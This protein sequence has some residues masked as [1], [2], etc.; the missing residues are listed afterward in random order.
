MHRRN[1]NQIMLRSAALMSMTPPEIISRK[2]ALPVLKPGM[3]VALIAPAGPVYPERLAKAITNLESLA[4]TP[5]INNE[6]VLSQ[7]GYLAG[8]DDLRLADLHQAFANPEI[9]AVWCIRGGYGCTRL[10]ADLNFKMIKKSGKPLIGFSD[11]TALHLSFSQQG[12]LNTVHGPVA[13]STL[14]P[15]TLAQVQETLFQ[16]RRPLTIST[17]ETHQPLGYVIHPGQAEGLLTGGNLSLLSALCGTRYQPSFRHKIVFIEDVGEQ[18]Y[19]LDRMLTQMLQSTDLAQA[20]G[21]VLGVFADCDPEE[22]SPSLSL[23]DTLE[24]RLKP[25]GIPAYYGLSFGHVDDHC[26]LPYHRPARLNATDMT[27]TLLG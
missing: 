18:P 21:L 23:R 3:R 19:R 26:C 8:P 12:I 5:V 11:I 10:L 27:L 15:Y 20:S 1:F 6:V 17:A 14:T 25:L 4:L 22:G 2:Y 13:S 7:H 24:D 9:E 16:S